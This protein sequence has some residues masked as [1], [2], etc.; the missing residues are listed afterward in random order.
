MLGDQKIR[1]KHIWMQNQVFTAGLFHKYNKKMFV[2]TSKFAFMTGI[3]RLSIVF[4]FF[5]FELLRHLL[6][7]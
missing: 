2:H 5:N 7:C 6:N 4:F 1:V 3:W